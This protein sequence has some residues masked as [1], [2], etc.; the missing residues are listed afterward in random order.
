VEVL[1]YFLIPVFWLLGM[2]SLRFFLAFT[3]LVFVIGVFISACSLILE[4]MELKR[5]PR[6]RD[7]LSLIAVA[8][9]ENFGYRQVNNW[10]RVVGWWQFARRKQGWGEM[11][12]KG[13]AAPTAGP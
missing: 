2:L 7:L 3:A 4:E 13:F 9:M 8:V 12:R 5:V 1:G 6:A 10:W 11:K